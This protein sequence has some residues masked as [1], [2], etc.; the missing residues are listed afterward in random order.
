MITLRRV[1]MALIVGFLP[2]LVGALLYVTRDMSNPSNVL[3]TR[4][5][6]ERIFLIT[7]VVLTGLALLML[8][9]AMHATRSKG[10]LW[11]GALLYLVGGA[12]I[13]AAELVGISDLVI[14][15]TS[16]RSMQST[17]ERLAFISQA[18]IGFGLIR[19]ERVSAAIGWATVIWNLVFLAVVLIGGTLYIPALHHT[20]PLVIGISLLRNHA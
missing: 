14:I 20:M 10:W 11:V 16:V 5:L 6:T 2:F 12:V 15:G 1:G 3:T 9:R 7:G 17:Y 19:S 13:V 18:L 4:V 8:A